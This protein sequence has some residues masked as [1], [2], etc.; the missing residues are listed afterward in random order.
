MFPGDYVPAAIAF[1]PRLCYDIIKE[2]K[3]VAERTSLPAEEFLRLYRQMEGLLERRYAGRKLSAGSVV[4]EYLRDP[5]S[6]PVRADLDLCREIRNLLTHNV[7]AEGEPVVTPSAAV[8]DALAAIVDYVQRPR[9]AVD[10][11]TPGDRIV[12]A[13]PNDSVLDL[14]RR[15]QRLGY[16]HV[17]VRDR[18]GLVGVFSAA[19]LFAHLCRKGFDTVDDGLKVGML[20]GAL[21]FG[22]ERSDKYRFLP[23][24]TTLAVVR[25]AFEKRV[26]RNS[27]LAAVFI[28]EDG[29][30]QSR[31]VAML[32]PWD[33]LRDAQ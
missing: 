22:D 7:D 20:K 14:M 3:R 6:L 16:S 10:Y 28:T 18:T 12:F 19:S 9:L 4:M 33:V 21:D 26:E 2:V 17:P 13:H 32:T 11:G 27:H 15:M 31:I 1:C 8:L 25:D 23:E 5:D 24:D 29:T 30:R